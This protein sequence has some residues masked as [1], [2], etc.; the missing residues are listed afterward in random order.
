MKDVFIF[1]PEE[2]RKLTGTSDFRNVSGHSSAQVFQAGEYYVKTDEEGCLQREYDMMKRFYTDGIGCE[3]V[4]YLS[5]GRDWL[6]SRAAEGNDL[7]GDLNDPETLCRILADALKRVHALPPGDAPVSSRFQRSMDSKNG[8]EDGGCYDPSVLMDR[9]AVRSRTEAW[10]IMQESGH[11]LKCDTLIHGDA[12]LPNILQKDGRF[13]CLI[14]PA[15]AGIGDRHI[16]LY[17]ALWSLQYNLKT[18]AYAGLFLD[19]YGREK[20]REE[21]LKVIAAFELFG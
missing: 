13:T 8:P 2:I 14:D 15:M 10:K 16:D 12:C 19:L 9:Y 11:Q 21:M 4:L 5:C 20:F 7:T 17:W 6:C 18:D 1:L 3:P